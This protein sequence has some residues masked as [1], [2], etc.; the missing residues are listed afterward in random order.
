MDI[1]QH[2]TKKLMGQWRNQRGSQKIPC[3]KWKWKHN[4][5]K[6]MDHIKSSSKREIQEARKISNKPLTLHIKKENQNPML[7]E[8]RK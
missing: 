7:T 2:S 4:V 8:R 1:K 3:N 6:S 5:P